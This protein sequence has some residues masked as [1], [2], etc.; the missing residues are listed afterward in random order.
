MD[1]PTYS[2]WN[3]NIATTKNSLINNKN[4]N[5]AGNNKKKNAGAVDFKIDT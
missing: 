2:F 5:A 1:V 3:M 4:I